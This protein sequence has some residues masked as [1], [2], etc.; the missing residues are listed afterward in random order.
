MKGQV[1]ILLGLVGIA[2]V[3]AAVTPAPSAGTPAAKPAP[4]SSA[5]ASATASTG[6]LKGVLSVSANGQALRATEGMDAVIYYRPKTP[7]AVTAEAE[8]AIMTTRRKQFVPRILAVPQGTTVRFPNEDPILHNVFSTSTENAFDV[9][10]YGKG[11]GKSHVFDRIGLVR[12]YCNVHHSMYGFVLV[13]DTPFHGRADAKGRFELSGLPLGEGELIVFHDRAPPLRQ[14]VV[15]GETGELKLQL[16][17]S[18]RKVPP[19]ANKFGK[20]YQRTPNGNY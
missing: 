14:K 9:G 7:V 10:Q 4:P 20:P 13:L 8:P 11:D 15:V 16:D 18:K 5:T 17:L 6:V 3:A 12:V 2:G 19:H 1:A